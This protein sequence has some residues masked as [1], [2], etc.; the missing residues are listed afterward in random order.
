MVG[1]FPSLLALQVLA[2]G[3]LV[4]R[5]RRA[6]K[7]EAPGREK[8]PE[9]PVSLIVPLKGGAYALRDCLDSLRRQDHSDFELIF[10][11]EDAKDEAV[12]ILREQLS[13]PVDGGCRKCRHVV[14]GHA[15][16]SGQKNHNLLAG[17]RA[18]D[19]ARPILVFCDVGHVAPPDWLRK[20]VAPLSAG[21]ADVTTGYH[22]LTTERPG[23][24]AA[25]RAITV[26]VLS[27]L[28]QVPS[29]TQPWGGGT[30]LRRSLFEKLKLE[31]FWARQIVD[32]VSLARLL[33]EQG[34]RVQTVPDALTR[35]T[36]DSESFSDWSDW[37]FR[38][39]F[40]LKIYF[41]GAW[42]LG[43][44]LGYL[45]AALLI[46]N[47]F[48]PPGAIPW[49]LLLLLIARLRKHHPAPGPWGSWLAGGVTAVFVACACHA[50]TV[51]ARR[52][53]WRGIA[54]RVKPDG[55]LAVYR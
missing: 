7:M 33:K 53:T 35:T 3:W 45:A 2:L 41:P 29:L 25:G 40:F 39:L 17:V 47:L 18:T 43:G 20:L 36:V 34:I 30:A 11:T 19:P 28:Q 16:T 23:V 31:E 21:Q 14:A 42:L 38:Q 24:A 9:S 10:V 8:T 51:V 50:R 5:E 13:R 37:L 49:M 48:S 6:Q 15:E 44:A 27:R 22:Y 1:L 26:L 55:S 54:Y 52:M 46:A 4:G 32:D 12:P